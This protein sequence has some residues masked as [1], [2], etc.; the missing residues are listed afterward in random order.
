MLNSPTKLSSARN[1]SGMV[2]TLVVVLFAVCSVPAQA[3]HIEIPTIRSDSFALS[4]TPLQVS[5]QQVRN[6]ADYVVGVQIDT[7]VQQS[8]AIEIGDFVTTRSGGHRM[9]DFQSFTAVPREKIEIANNRITVSGLDDCRGSVYVL[10]SIPSATKVVISVNGKT[11]FAGIP[12]KGAIIHRGQLVSSE[13]LGR[14]QLFSRLLFPE[15][16]DP[17][18]DAIR[19]KNGYSLSQNALNRH[20]IS[21]N[22][23]SNHPESIW[24]DLETVTLAIRIDTQGNVVSAKALN[25]REPFVTEAVNSVAHARFKPFIVNNAPVDSTGDVTIVFSKD[26]RVSSTLQ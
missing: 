25:G 22:K 2:W 14:H 17:Q 9:R 16:D 3:Q 13:F 4:Q 10:L 23:P 5:L 18:P 20:L 19:T 6:D 7:S 24:G 11:Q 1:M 15:L 8:G 26:G 12:P 21:F